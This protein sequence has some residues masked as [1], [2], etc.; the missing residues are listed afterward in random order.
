VYSDIDMSS[1]GNNVSRNAR[2]R[3][4]RP[5]I[6]LAAAGFPE[7]GPTLAPDHINDWVVEEDWDVDMETPPREGTR[8]G[9]D[10]PQTAPRERQRQHQTNQ[11]PYYTTGRYKT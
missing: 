6:D 5:R 7:G 3:R 4:G 9:R 10:D 11:S 8:R 2:I 1:I